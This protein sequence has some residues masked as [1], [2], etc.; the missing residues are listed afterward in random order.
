MCNG[1]NSKVITLLMNGFS[2]SIG[3][4][5]DI[6]LPKCLFSNGNDNNVNDEDTSF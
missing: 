2:S 5:L 1:S 4:I 3:K 6:K